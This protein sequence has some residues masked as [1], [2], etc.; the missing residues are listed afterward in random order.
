MKLSE[1]VLWMKLYPDTV[2]VR[3]VKLSRAASMRLPRGSGGEV[4][5]LQQNFG[6]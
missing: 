1:V 6:M 5:Q 3:V 2:H 4:E